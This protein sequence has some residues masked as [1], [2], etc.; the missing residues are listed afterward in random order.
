[1]QDVLNVLQRITI[2]FARSG[3]TL[4]RINK[5]NTQKHASEIKTS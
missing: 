5:T 2:N 3:S 1:M 4:E